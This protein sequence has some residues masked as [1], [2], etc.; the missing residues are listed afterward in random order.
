MRRA[1][2][3]EAQPSPHIGRQSRYAHH[4][5]ATL[6]RREIGGSFLEDFAEVFAEEGRDLPGVDRFPRH[7]RGCVMA[8]R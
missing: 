7:F 3:G 2:Y 5:V 6:L 8:A 1:S 4:V